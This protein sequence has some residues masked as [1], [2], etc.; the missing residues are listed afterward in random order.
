MLYLIIAILCGTT[1]SV[2]FKICQRMGISTL[3]A[4]LFNYV[5]AAIVSWVPLFI[6]SSRGGAPV[7]NPLAQNWIWLALIQGA[8]FLGGFSVMSF[9]TRAC[10]VALT[11]VAARASL[12]LPVILSWLILSQPAPAWLSVILII[13]ALVLVATGNGTGSK[14]EASAEP[15]GLLAHP[16]LIMGL[17]FL[18]YGISDFTLK[19]VQHRVSILCDGDATLTESHLSALTGTIFIMA[20]LLSIVVLIFRPKQKYERGTL[21]SLVAGVL[22]GLANVGCTACILRSLT[23]LSTGVFYPLYNIGIVL[24]G[25]LAGMLLFKERLRPLQ[26]IGFALAILAI[27]LF[28]K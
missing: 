6:A 15:K 17:V 11:N 25:T 10:G 4:I 28:F 7:V 13:I 12:I 19:L 3:W 5:T 27:A 26:Y 21:S 1:F 2:I 18:F 23:V 24:A 20:S 9:S 14:V 8:L 16:R 22:L